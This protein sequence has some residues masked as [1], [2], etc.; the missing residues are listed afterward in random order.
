MLCCATN[1]RELLGNRLV[2]DYS[3]NRTTQYMC[4]NT[5]VLCSRALNL[6]HMLSTAGAVFVC[7]LHLGLLLLSDMMTV[8]P[9]KIFDVFFRRTNAVSCRCA[10]PLVG[11][12][13]NVR[14]Q[15]VNTGTVSIYLD[16]R[17]YK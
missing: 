9:T 3:S 15:S 16:T 8:I 4:L 13:F 2:G 6:D 11:G 17:Q 12:Q 10:C 7:S 14:V 5:V 1:T